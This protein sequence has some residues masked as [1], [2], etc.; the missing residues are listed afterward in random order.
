[1]AERE[2]GV[3]W[4]KDPFGGD[5]PSSRDVVFGAGRSANFLRPEL[6]DFHP[7]LGHRHGCDA[8][9]LC[10]CAAQL[11]DLA[12]A[13]SELAAAKVRSLGPVD[14]DTVLVVSG[15]DDFE[16]VEHLGTAVHDHFLDPARRPLVFVVRDRD[17]EITALGV[18]ELRA[19]G[20]ER[21]EPI[22]ASTVHW[23]WKY[24]EEHAQELIHAGR[25]V[26]IR[27][28]ADVEH[29]DAGER[30]AGESYIHDDY[31]VDDLGP[32]ENDG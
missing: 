10:S 30:A 18:D 4:G 25:R 23:R 31:V 24:A 1:M 9:E 20:W 13:A 8:N 27:T 21:S 3:G 7:E 5:G 29:A 17:A 28:V 11:I 22:V 14:H 16:A 32:K 12:L 26:R 19:H 6:A 2:R 15:P